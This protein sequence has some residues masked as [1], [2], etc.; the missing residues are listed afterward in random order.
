VQ[1][2]SSA[3]QLASD[4]VVHYRFNGYAAESGS[5]IWSQASEY[6]RNWPERVGAN[7]TR[8]H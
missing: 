6:P 5:I 2:A 3:I 7:A 8:A 4:T 1:K